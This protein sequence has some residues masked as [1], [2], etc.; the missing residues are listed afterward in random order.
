MICDYISLRK[1]LSTLLNNNEKTLLKQLRST[2]ELKTFIENVK[3]DY[4][5]TIF[6]P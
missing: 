2:Q 3:Q 6:N 5:N 1:T 4:D